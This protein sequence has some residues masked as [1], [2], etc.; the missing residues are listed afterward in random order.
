MK[1]TLAAARENAGYMLK[2]ASRLI[3]VTP[4]AL[5]NYESGSR[6]IPAIRLQVLLEKYNTKFEDIILISKR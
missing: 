5:S 2:D 1:L 4:S 3:G 6:K